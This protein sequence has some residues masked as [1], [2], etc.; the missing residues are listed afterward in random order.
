MNVKFLFGAAFVALLSSSVA[1][2]ASPPFGTGGYPGVTST[3]SENVTE[4][5]Y[6]YVLDVWYEFWSPDEPECIG[7]VHALE[8]NVFAVEKLGYCG[9]I[10][11][12][13]DD[14]LGVGGGGY[15]HFNKKVGDLMPIDAITNIYVR[16]CNTQ[17][18]NPA[19]GNP[20]Y[21][22]DMM[23]LKEKYKDYFAN[24]KVR[25][26]VDVISAYRTRITTALDKRL[27]ELR[28]VMDQ[29]ALK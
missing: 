15:C 13:I 5:T 7:I 12:R 28:G 17:L 8:D 20:A 1:F 10:F 25:I 14:A 24:S 27:D 6:P 19:Y 22:E 16:N 29:T 26:P 11:S 2:A 4:K 18:G 23:N 21:I 9:S 3:T